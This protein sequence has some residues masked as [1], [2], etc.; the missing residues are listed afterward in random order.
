[1]VLALVEKGPTIVPKLIA[2]LNASGSMGQAVKMWYE[3][4]KAELETVP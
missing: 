2:Q 3:Q 1:V 4:A